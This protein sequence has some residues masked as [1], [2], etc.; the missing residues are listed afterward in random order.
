M[1]AH[2]RKHKSLIV[3]GDRGA[4][5]GLNIDF[6]VVITYLGEVRGLLND[7]IELVAQR[8]AIYEKSIGFAVAGNDERIHGGRTL[9]NCK[10]HGA[11]C[12]A[13]AKPRRTVNKVLRS[14]AYF[15]NFAT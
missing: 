7:D 6:K 3:E 4:T 14:V 2:D 15:C 12:F 10:C 8:A 1:W 11:D 9:V 13:N 5:I